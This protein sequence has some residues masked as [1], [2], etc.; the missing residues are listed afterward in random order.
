MKVKLKKNC[1]V[2]EH[3]LLGKQGEIILVAK[4][5]AHHLVHKGLAEL[6]EQ[7]KSKDAK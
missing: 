1:N 6:E 7:V 3:G 2:N 4:A 5:E